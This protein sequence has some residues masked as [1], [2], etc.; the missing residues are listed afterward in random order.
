MASYTLYPP[1]VD[2]SINS[3]IAGKEPGCRVYFSLSKFNSS[4]DFKSVHISIKKHGKG[5]TAIKTVAP[6]CS[7][8]IALNIHLNESETDRDNNI[9][10]VDIPES[11]VENG[12]IK[13]TIYDIQIRLC[14]VDDYAGGMTEAAWVN[15][16]GGDFSEWS[17]IAITKAIGEPVISIPSIHYVGNTDMTHSVATKNLNVIGT[18]SNPEDQ[19]ETLARYKVVLVKEFEKDFEVLEQSDTIYTYNNKIEY[20]FNYEPLVNNTSYTIYLYYDTIN[21]YSVV[22]ERIGSQGEGYFQNGI[23]LL[24]NIHW[25]TIEKCPFKIAYAEDRQG[26]YQATAA[27]EAD[28][29]FIGLKIYDEEDIERNL[30]YIVRRSSSRDNFSTWEDIRWIT[31]D[32][33]KVSTAAIINDFTIESGVWY[34]YGLQL[35]DEE[36][37]TRGPIAAENVT[38]PILRDCEFTYLLGENNKQLRVAFNNT[39]SNYRVNTN[40]AV[41]PTIDGQFPYTNR[42]GASYY[43][44]FTLNGLI[45]FNMDDFFATRNEVFKYANIVN[46]FSEYN[47]KNDID[48]YDMI[49]ER[50]FRD[51]VMY[52]LYDGKPKLYKSPTEGNMIVKLNQVTLTPTDSLN[53]LTYSFSAN[54]TEIAELNEVNLKKYKLRN[55]E[56][57]IGDNVNLNPIPLHTSHKR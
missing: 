33:K 19:S 6:Y 42:A 26:I 27:Q 46:L 30:T 52:F 18:Y 50:E 7:L 15:E 3:F 22:K 40:D 39:V 9:Y 2:S 20:T 25:E 29:G 47:N 13:G 35:Y 17:T 41:Q 57:F 37:K 56:T 14:T 51:K 54:V 31:L 1:I 36:T 44:T 55:L 4:E 24:Y 43:K 16:H 34:K 48:Q 23:R 21:N 53:R 38:K 12:W 49:Y 10:C 5:T 28:Y 32:D 8:G 45:S 11:I